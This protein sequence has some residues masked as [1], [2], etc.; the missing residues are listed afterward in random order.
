V[1]RY[2]KVH[3]EHH[4]AFGTAGDSENTYLRALTAAFIV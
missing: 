2:R 1:R 3:F 4:C